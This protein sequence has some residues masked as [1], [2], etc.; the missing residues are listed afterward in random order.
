MF[1]FCQQK[2]S[3][4][5]KTINEVDPLHIDH[6]KNNIVNWLLLS[7]WGVYNSKKNQTSLDF[8]YFKP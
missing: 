4:V 3:Y 1:P 6:N 5:D 2:D 8:N 7:R